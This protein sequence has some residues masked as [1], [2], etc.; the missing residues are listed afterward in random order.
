MHLSLVIPLRYIYNHL[1]NAS[2][3]SH[4]LR[5]I[6][7]HLLRNGIFPDRLKFAVVKPLHSKGDKNH[8]DKLQVCLIVISF[9]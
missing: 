2:P 3:I 9:F 8:Y 6:Y 1:L 7:N 4:P 5:Y